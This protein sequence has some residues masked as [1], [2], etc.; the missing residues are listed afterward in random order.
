M[1]KSHKSVAV[2]EVRTLQD[3]AE[4]LVGGQRRLEEAM[5]CFNKKRD[6]SHVLCIHN[7]TTW[8]F[9]NEGR[10]Y[11]TFHPIVLCTKTFF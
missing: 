7:I 3:L 5:L 6:F 2:V 4:I 9:K 11:L 10:R 8:K 1:K